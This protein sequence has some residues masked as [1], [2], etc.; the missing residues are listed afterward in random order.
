MVDNC[1]SGCFTK[2]QNA[3]DVSSY[4]TTSLSSALEQCVNSLNWIPY[5]NTTTL[6]SCGNGYSNTEYL[7]NKIQYID[8]GFQPY[9]DLQSD[10]FY[11]EFINGSSINAIPYEKEEKCKVDKGCENKKGEEKEM[12]KVIDYVIVDYEILKEDKVVKVMFSDGTFEKMVCH[13]D[14][15][16]D[17]RTCLFIAMAKHLYKDELTWEGIEYKYKEFMFT[18]KYI[19]VVD[20][21]I[22]TH[23][24][25]LKEEAK[26]RAKEEDK[27][28]ALANKKR[29]HARYVERR[30]QR[31][32]NE[33]A[34]AVCEGLKMYDK[35]Q[36]EKARIAREEYCDTN[37]ERC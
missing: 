9:H 15:V 18:K 12:F 17:L 32:L 23:N 29:K 30:K 8:T 4:A 11:I 3:V 2:L 6:N 13:E 25:K 7:D 27:K 16:F 19:K 28:R 5:D 36:E 34:K 20:T 14:D 31:R 26:E 22:K 1:P 24:K 37:C 21:V 35:C 10:D 33:Q